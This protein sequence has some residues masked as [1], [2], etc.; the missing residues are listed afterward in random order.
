MLKIF[1]VFAALVLV[2]CGPSS[3][4]KERVAVKKKIITG[5]KELNTAVFSIQ[6]PPA[7][8][9]SQEGQMGSS[10]ILM[11]PLEGD[12]DLFK[13]NVNLVIEDL[14]GQKVS[15]VQYADAAGK[16]IQRMMTNSNILESKEISGSGDDHYKMIYTA[17]QGTYSLKFEQHYRVKNGKAYVLTFTCEKNQPSAFQQDGEN[18]L[19][20]FFLK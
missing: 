6:Y 9:L 14:R 11:S 8:E 1:S 16:Q 3:E 10:L 18:I 2:A 4:K 13:E 20:S 15:L 5:W 17:D 19:N 12:K 7:W